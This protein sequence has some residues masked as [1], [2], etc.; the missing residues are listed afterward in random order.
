MLIDSLLSHLAPHDCI[1]CHTEGDLL[2]ADCAKLLLSVPERCYRCHELMDGGRTCT[3]CRQQSQLFAVHAR[4][5]YK[6]NA[7]QL[8][9]QLKF[10]SAQAAAR[11]IAMQ[12]ASKL[13][14]SHKLIIVPVPTATSRARMRGY[15]QA[16]LIAKH[17]AR[18]TGND[19]SHALRRNGQHHQ[20]GS[21][22]KERITQLQNAYRCV[23]HNALQNKHVILIDDVLTTGATLEA[24]AQVIKQ[25]GAARV[26]GYVYA[27]A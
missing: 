21:S 6:G 17:L 7:K 12:M 16:V 22:R 2:C 24:A 14:R 26:S 9:L 11:E 3:A 13:P 25:A 23:R 1:G 20:V 18:I 19:Y 10:N 4:T 5:A 27:Q 15:D 8:V